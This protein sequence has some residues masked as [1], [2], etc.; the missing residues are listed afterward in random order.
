MCPAIAASTAVDNCATRSAVKSRIV[1]TTVNLG[2]RACGVARLRPVFDVFI[3]G[4]RNS[5]RS[6]GSVPSL[7]AIV[8]AWRFIRTMMPPGP[9]FDRITPSA[10][11]GV[12]V[13]AG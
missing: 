13:S 2:P 9:L 1:F 8:N 6:R 12:A 7:G 3:P 4:R 10:I 5:G 11:G